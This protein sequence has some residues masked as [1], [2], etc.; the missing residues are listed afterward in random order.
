[1]HHRPAAKGPPTADAVI[2][3]EQIRALVAG[4]RAQGRVSLLEPEGYE[5]LRC[6]GIPAAPHRFVRDAAEAASLDL[7]ALPGR[8][9][10]VK[11]A[12][13]EIVH[14]TDLGGVV[15]VAH[16]RDAVVGAIGEMAGRLGDRAA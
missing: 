11:V 13:P 9:L 2:D 14:K 16:D 15:V 7:T 1:M 12:A 4:V 3:L 8:R 10:V 6:A 5:L